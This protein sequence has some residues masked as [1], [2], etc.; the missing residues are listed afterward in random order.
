MLTERTTALWAEYGYF[1]SWKPVVLFAKNLRNHT[2]HWYFL[3]LAGKG[4]VNVIKQV[5]IEWRA[6]PGA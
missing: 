6:E 5:S 1:L 4:G 3:G 2:S